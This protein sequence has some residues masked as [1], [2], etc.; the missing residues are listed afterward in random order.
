MIHMVHYTLLGETEMGSAGE[1]PIKGY[2]SQA[3]QT[4]GGRGVTPDAS[5]IPPISDDRPA[6]PQKTQPQNNRNNLQS[7]VQRTGCDTMAVASSILDKVTGAIKR[8]AKA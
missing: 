3:H 8:P 1:H 2:P 6:M 4:M 5:P 7:C